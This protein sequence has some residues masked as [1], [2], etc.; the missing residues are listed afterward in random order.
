MLK[1][2]K[3]SEFNNALLGNS[4]LRYLVLVHIIVL[5]HNFNSAES[6]NKKI[7]KLQASL[8]NKIYVFNIKATLDLD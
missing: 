4:K 2:L 6:F 8:H 5:I 1:N 7:T 3:I